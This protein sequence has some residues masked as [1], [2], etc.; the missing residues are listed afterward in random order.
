MPYL[1]CPNCRLTL[2]KPDALMEGKKSR[3]CHSCGARLSERR[4][5]AVTARGVPRPRRDRQLSS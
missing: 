3:K 2:F 1:H 5:P 4:R